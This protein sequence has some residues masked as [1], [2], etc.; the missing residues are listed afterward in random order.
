MKDH[1]LLPGEGITA[2]VS[3]KRLY[4]GNKK[5]FQRVGFYD[6][7]PSDVA[8]LV[9]GWSNAGGTTG[10]ISI[11][12]EGIVGAYCVSDKIRAEA[13][14]VVN[15]L[16]KMGIKITMLTGDLRPAAIAIGS[17]IGLEADQIKSELLP[18]DKLNEIHKQVEVHKANNKWW[19]SKQTVLMCGDG[20]NDAPALALAD[21]SVAM[22]EGS[23]LAMETADITLLDSSLNKLLYIFHMGRRVIRTIIE[24]IA[25]SIFFK[26][27]V[28][29]LLFAGYGSLWLAI[30]AD[31]GAMIL[32]TLNGMKLLPSSKKEVDLADN[33]S[34]RDV[35]V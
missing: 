7:L 22:G 31:V 34:K 3:G 16:M 4:V 21:V 23:S 33:A 26:A 15:N 27:L 6:D 10:F 12:G 29:G 1:T 35:A 25:F 14:S 13:K 18:E 20:V 11:E 9:E 19:R 30:A 5:L 8:S 32:V 2:S 17:E 24:N 28:V